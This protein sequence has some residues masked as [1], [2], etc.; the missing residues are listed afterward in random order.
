MLNKTIHG[1]NIYAPS[2]NGK[3]WIDFSANINP[4]G[5]PE[6]VKKALIENIDT[7]S[8]YP[9]PLC[10]ELRKAISDKLHISM[11]MI[12]CGNGAADLIFRLIYAL[13][14]R[15]ALLLAP[16]FAEYE[17]ALK[18]VGCELSFFYL[19]EKEDFIWDERLLEWIPDVD[20]VLLC[21]PNNPTGIAVTQ[22][23]LV[24][25]ADC[26]REHH[27]FLLID[28]CFIDF[29]P[30]QKKYSFIDQLKQF[31][32]AAVLKAF[33]KLYAMA[34]IRLGYLLCSDQKLIQNMKQYGQ[35]WNVSTVAVKCG[36][37]A[38]SCEDY[39]QRTLTLIEKERAYLLNNLNN[40]GIKSY[41]SQT[42]YLLFRCGISDLAERLKSYNILI[43]DCSNY[44]GLEQGYF[45]IAVK[46]R[47]DNQYFIKAMK[48][49]LQHETMGE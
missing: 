39:V 48:E 16:T 9:D 34:G 13:K 26:C 22:E 23:L 12:E 10:R 43:R 33:T 28:E 20:M 46:S 1:G 3:P 7:Y 38:L 5:I 37:A 24:K 2:P 19:P 31:P 15:K 45:R 42:N 29:L 27:A 11:E 25:V 30:E 4:L 41:P 49:I 21:N 8:A 36:V 17:M 32:E 14:P 6:K 18:A 40:L 35:P 47:E 44:R